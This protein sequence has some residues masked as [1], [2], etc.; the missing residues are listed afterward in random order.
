MRVVGWATRWCGLQICATVSAEM[1]AEILHTNRHQCKQ[2]TVDG[3]LDRN[4]QRK[5][6]SR[7]QPTL[8]GAEGGLQTEVD[9]CFVA[10]NSLLVP[11]SLSSTLIFIVLPSGASTIFIMVIGLPSR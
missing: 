7:W 2:V 11:R 5:C 10:M 4:E 1:P 3:A 8:H 9:Y 6:Q